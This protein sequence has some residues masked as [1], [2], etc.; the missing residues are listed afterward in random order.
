MRVLAAKVCSV[1]LMP[2]AVSTLGGEGVLSRFAARRFI[3]SCLHPLLSPPLCTLF[4]H[5]AHI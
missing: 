3:R 2:V 1:G 4:C 5:G